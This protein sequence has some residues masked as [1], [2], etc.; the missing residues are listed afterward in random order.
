MNLPTASR[1]PHA[2]LL[3]LLAVAATPLIAGCGSS[4]TAGSSTTGSSTAGSSSTSL[5]PSAASNAKLPPRLTARLNSSGE[6]SL[7]DSNGQPVTHLTSG[8]YTVAVNV[9]SPSGD[10]H[11]TGPLFK[12]RTRPHFTG[13]VLWGVHFVH[14]TY[15]FLNDESRTH[16]AYVITVN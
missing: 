16:A 10:F 3:A 5:V 1:R 15:H 13:I 9:E 4:S 6:V 11:L 14:G 7:T 12:R 2:R 8:R